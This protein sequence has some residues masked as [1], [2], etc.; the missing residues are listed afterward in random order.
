MPKQL[1]DKRIKIIGINEMTERREVIAEVWAHYR[2]MS[3]KETYECGADNSWSNVYF[4]I[5]KPKSFEVTTYNEIEYKGNTYII[6][7]MDL[8]EDIDGQNM[9]IQAR[10]RL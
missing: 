4:T 9:R 1:K 8:F 2:S 5:F 6:E 7:G 3:V 10:C